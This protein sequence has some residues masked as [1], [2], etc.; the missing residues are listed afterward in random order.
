[1]TLEDAIKAVSTLTLQRLSSHVKHGEVDEAASAYC[2]LSG[3]TELV[4]M[5]D[6]E[7]TQAL[8]AH[9]LS[10]S[11]EASLAVGAMRKKL[12]A[13]ESELQS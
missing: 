13:D 12:D 5:A 4:E 6:V 1:M 3:L 7:M 8:R 2:E 11:S 10:I 9:L